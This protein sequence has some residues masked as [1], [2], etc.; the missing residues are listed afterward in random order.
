[1]W[2]IC[3]VNKEE[4]E[5]MD[6]DESI[7]N[8]FEPYENESEQEFEEILKMSTEKYSNDIIERKTKVQ[9]L[10]NCCSQCNK[11][12]HDNQELAIHLHEH[13]MK[14]EGNSNLNDETKCEL[15]FEQFSSLE[16][17]KIHIQDHFCDTTRDIIDSVNIKL[18]NK[19]N[20]YQINEE[21][22]CS[23]CKKEFLTADECSE[24][25]KKHKV[26][27]LFMCGICNKVFTRN[28]SR[29]RHELNHAEKS[30]KC[31]QC[32][33]TFKKKTELR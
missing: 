8:N 21:Y 2:K 17:L 23:Q 6:Y 3:N 1:M 18:D 10:N 29:K 26:K 13:V 31:R 33:K 30:F 28:S 25:I 7:L 15:C 12:F 24:H 4:S 19:K 22:H 27:K 9:R 32:G 14:N 16:N 5:T 20:N 11:C